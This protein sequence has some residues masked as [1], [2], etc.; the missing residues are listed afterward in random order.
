MKTGYWLIGLALA[1]AAGAWIVPRQPSA[2]Q[3]ATAVTPLAEPGPRIL[4]PRDHPAFLTMADGRRQ[5]VRSLLND[6]RPL[7]FGDYLWNDAGV[8]AGPVWVRVDPAHQLLSVFRDGHEIGTAVILYGT[9][10][11][12][13]PTGVFPILAKAE[14]HRSSLYDAQMPYMLRLT[15]DG[16]AI[17]AS[18]VRNGS[19]THGC[20][21]VPEDFARRLF[22]QVKRGDL[23]SILPAS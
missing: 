15:G 8:P 17:H 5:P 7:A 13:T 12:P 18:A 20:I 4:Y 16:V 23:V 19:A 6:A 10:H 21:G 9:D 2:E 3:L 14:T 1:A 11:K 22:A